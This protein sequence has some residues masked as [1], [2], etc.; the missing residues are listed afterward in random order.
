MKREKSKYSTAK[1]TSLETYLTPLKTEDHF[2][3]K[4]LILP[5]NYRRSFLCSQNSLTLTSQASHLLPAQESSDVICGSKVW[6]L[7]ANP[8]LPQKHSSGRNATEGTKWQGAAMAHS[9]VAIVSAQ[10]ITP[11]KGLGWEC[12]SVSSCLACADPQHHKK[13]RKQ[14]VS[15][16]TE[17][18]PKTKGT[19]WLLAETFSPH[20]PKKSK[21][22][23]SPGTGSMRVHI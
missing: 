9:T 2:S 16:G 12:N 8:Q 19:R 22:I 17:Q 15:K 14:E 7:P 20:P 11:R 3:V 5:Q 13:E 6:S 10:S 18:K 4:L 23:Q 1:V 21:Y